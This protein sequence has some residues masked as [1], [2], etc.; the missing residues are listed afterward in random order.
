MSQE[1]DT[2]RVTSKFAAIQVWSI[3]VGVGIAV[4]FVLAWY[5][6]RSHG[7]LRLV[8]VGPVYLA[9]MI[10]SFVA[11]FYVVR[12]LRLIVAPD[13][14]HGSWVTAIRRLSIATLVAVGLGLLLTAVDFTLSSF[15]VG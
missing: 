15:P 14:V 10:A 11:W 8:V 5:G 9:A 1:S 12:S 7:P 6:V 4:T 3:L 13:F 2:N